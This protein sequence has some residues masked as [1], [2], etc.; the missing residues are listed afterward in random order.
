MKL[1][2][3]NK[4]WQSVMMT[5]QLF[6]SMSVTMGPSKI[7]KKEEFKAEVYLPSLSCHLF[8]V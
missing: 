3:A 7:Y 8:A 1:N 5:M 6:P 2:F 4:T